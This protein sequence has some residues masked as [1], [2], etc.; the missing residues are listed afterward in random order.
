METIRWIE[1]EVEEQDYFMTLKYSALKNLWNE[2]S[3][4]N[5][6]WVAPRVYFP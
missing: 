4:E 1:P 5:I 2:A 6:V 3:T